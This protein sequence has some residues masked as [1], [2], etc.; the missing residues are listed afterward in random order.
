ML[1]YSLLHSCFTFSF[2]RLSL[3]LIHVFMFIPTSPLPAVSFPHLLLPPR[4]HAPHHHSLTMPS[5][6]PC[7]CCHSHTAQTAHALSHPPSPSP[8]LPLPP[9]PSPSLPL[10]HPLPSHRLKAYSHQL[11]MTPLHSLKVATLMRQRMTSR[12]CGVCSDSPPP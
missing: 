7:V 6:S 12:R 3:S 9:P 5:S 2:T 10:P 8:S 11:K 4:T 1:I